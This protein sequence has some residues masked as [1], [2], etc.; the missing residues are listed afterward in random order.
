M[1]LPHAPL[2][3]FSLYAGCKIVAPATHLYVGRPGPY[4]GGPGAC[5]LPL[6]ASL[7]AGCSRITVRAYWRYAADSR[8]VPERSA[9]SSFHSHGS[10][11]VAR[12]FF[13]LCPP[14]AV[15]PPNGL[16][17]VIAIVGSGIPFFFFHARIVCTRVNSQHRGMVHALSYHEKS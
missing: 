1:G 15:L 17:P 16:R 14:Y 12:F 9:A 4:T 11:R 2:L 13:F 8:F 10:P 3:C 5:R 6:R 7:A